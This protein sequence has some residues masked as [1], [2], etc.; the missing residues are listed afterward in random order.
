MVVRA[1]AERVESVFA[2]ALQPDGRL[3]RFFLGG[4][5]C[6]QR[7]NRDGFH[8]GSV[9]FVGKKYRRRELAESPFT[10]LAAKLFVCVIYDTTVVAIC[11]AIGVG[12][13]KMI[14]RSDFGEIMF[15]VLTFVACMTAFSL[16][17]GAWGNI[18][19]KAITLPLFYIMPSVLFSGAI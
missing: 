16:F 13:F 5:D 17:M 14:C 7:T 18:P 12:A 11:L 10:V 3:H 1:G 19:Q 6:A 8:V 9:V 2:N 4:I 15:L